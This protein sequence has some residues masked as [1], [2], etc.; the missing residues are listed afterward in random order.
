MSSLLPIIDNFERALDAEANKEDNFYK[1][2]EMIYG[3]LIKAL[4]DNGVEEMTL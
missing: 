2:V 1:G 3:Q 4:K